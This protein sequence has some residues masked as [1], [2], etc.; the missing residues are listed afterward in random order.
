MAECLFYQTHIYVNT[1]THARTRVRTQAGGWRKT[2]YNYR[3]AK[4]ILVVTGARIF[5]S[6]PLPLS[7]S[8]CLSLSPSSPLWRFEIRVS[9]SAY[10]S[11]RKTSA[12]RRISLSDGERESVDANATSYC[13]VISILGKPIIDWKLLTRSP[14][15]FYRLPIFVI[16][17]YYGKIHIVFYITIVINSNL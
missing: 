8:L 3:L 14:L 1:C 2:K 11:L 16:Y 15:A 10:F 7:S 9:V 12:T 5:L 6:Q 17:F 4:N 13:N